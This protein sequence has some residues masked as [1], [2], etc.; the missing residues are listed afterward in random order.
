MF[1]GLL[2]SLIICDKTN[3]TFDAKRHLPK[4][5]LPFNYVVKEA[6]L[7]ML[8]HILQRGNLF[9]FVILD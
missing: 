2:G 9:V 3:N 1:L 4:R 5:P 7:K 6:C 8:L